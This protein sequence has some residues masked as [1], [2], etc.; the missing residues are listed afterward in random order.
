MTWHLDRLKRK[1]GRNPFSRKHSAEYSKMPATVSSIY[2][3]LL[4]RVSRGYIDCITSPPLARSFPTSFYQRDDRKLF[5]ARGEGLEDPGPFMINFILVNPRLCRGPR[6]EYGVD[7]SGMLGLWPGG[8]ELPGKK[9]RPGGPSSWG[10]RPAS[11]ASG[12]LIGR[13]AVAPPRRE[14]LPWRLRGLARLD[15]EA[16][17]A[18]WF[19]PGRSLPPGL[20]RDGRPPLGGAHFNPPVV[21]RRLDSTR[22]HRL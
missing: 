19:L 9:H 22:S 2:F 16:V 11:A 17:A 1:T 5:P 12:G 8:K 10:L 3:W 4:K 6:I 21:G 13:P 15:P 7:I 14:P 18:S 20:A